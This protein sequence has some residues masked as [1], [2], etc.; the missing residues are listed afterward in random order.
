MRGWSAVRRPTVTQAAVRSDA[1][2]LLRTEPPG[3]RRWTFFE[4][5][6]EFWTRVEQDR[7]KPV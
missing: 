3:N 2:E 7:A 4:K 1:D 6:K 5:S